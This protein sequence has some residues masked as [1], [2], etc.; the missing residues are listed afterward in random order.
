M[1]A[2]VGSGAKLVGTEMKLRLEQRGLLHCLPETR[3]RGEGFWD[4]R[5][6]KIFNFFPK[7]V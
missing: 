7:V 4:Q 6:P 2:L 1:K 3:W 5:S